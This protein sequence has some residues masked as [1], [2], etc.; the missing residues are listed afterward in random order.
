[1]K[2]EIGGKV[3]PNI[4]IALFDT[5]GHIIIASK[6]IQ[7]CKYYKEDNEETSQVCKEIRLSK[8]KETI[9]LFMCNNGLMMYRFSIQS[10]G[11]TIAYLVMSQFLMN[12]TDKFRVIDQ[13]RNFKVDENKIKALIDEVPIIDEEKIKDIVIFMKNL[14]YLLRDMIERY[15]K[16]NE[17]EEKVKQGLVILKIN[18]RVNQNPEYEVQKVNNMMY[19]LL[20]ISDQNINIRWVDSDLIE[21][22]F[23]SLEELSIESK[24]RTFHSK[25]NNGYYDIEYELMKTHVNHAYEILKEINFDMP[26]AEIVEQPLGEAFAINYLNE[27]KSTLFDDKVVEACINVVGSKEWELDDIYNYLYVQEY[28]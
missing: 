12:E 23:S 18:K 9:G 5:E 17:L 14:V 20:D 3:M 19:K 24:K 6:W 11:V 13:L 27:E 16:A 28:V 4:P 25:Q 8:D 22:I 21:Y 2:I 7:V 1:L 26:I 15:L 10:Q